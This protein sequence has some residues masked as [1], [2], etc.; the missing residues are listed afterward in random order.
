MFDADIL[1]LNTPYNALDLRDPI[2]PDRPHRR[3][4][5][6][7][8]TTTVA[9]AATANCPTWLGFLYRIM[10]EKPEMVRYLQRV[11]GYML[12]GSVKEHVL[13]FAHGTGANGKSTFANVL[14]GILGTGPDGYAAVAPI[15]TFTASRTEQHPTDLAMLRSVRCVVAH[16]TE[17]G[18][19]WAIS[20]LKMMTGEDQITARFMR[21]DFFTFTPRFKLLILGNHKPALRGVDEATRRRFHLIPFD[22]TIPPAERDP[23]LG[24]KLR[25]EYPDILRWMIEGCAA[26]IQGG[27]QP[28]QSVRAAT[29]AYLA[30]EDTFT[31]WLS[32]CCR[33]GAGEWDALVNLFASWKA[34]CEA[35][36]EYVGRRRELAKQFDLRG[37]ARHND[38]VSRRLGWRGVRVLGSWEQP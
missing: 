22:V 28:P 32:E 13:F 6:M 5:Y 35:N 34:W 16:E 24:D 36:G 20:K 11:C 18:R 15:S 31:A 30:D 33:R 7:T 29:E 17:E 4:D 25:A 1:A 3:M 14:L 26:Y 10:G 27:L 21:Q 38:D 19:S 12:T 2:T 37:Y 23:E 9:P 8:R